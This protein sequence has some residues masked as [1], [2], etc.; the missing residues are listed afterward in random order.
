MIFRLK[1]S[2]LEARLKYLLSLPSP[3][4]VATQGTLSLEIQGLAGY[5]SAKWTRVLS[6]SGDPHATVASAS[7][8]NV[9]SFPTLELDLT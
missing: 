4:E 5:N 6:S 1:S 8:W 9:A 3:P 7:T 2:K